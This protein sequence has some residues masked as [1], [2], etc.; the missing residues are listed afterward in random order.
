MENVLPSQSPSYPRCAHALARVIA[1]H[2]ARQLQGGVMLWSV[3]GMR[4]HRSSAGWP[5]LEVLSNK[6]RLE[7][8]EQQRG[9][10]AAEDAAHKEDVEVVEVLGEAAKHIAGDIRQ[11]SLLPA[12]ALM[13]TV[14]LR[15]ELGQPCSPPSM[16]MAYS[17]SSCLR[18]CHAHVLSARDPTMVPKIIDDPKPAMN[19]RPMSPRP[20]P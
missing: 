13:K 17:S 1:L 7:S 15:G 3:C 10:H 5:H 8:R 19:S 18:Q 4:Q 12:P 6:P 16:T 9:G 14:D 20:K 2:Q 11:R